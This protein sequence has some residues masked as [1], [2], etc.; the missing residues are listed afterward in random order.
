MWSYLIFK[1]N[2]K[3]L[4]EDDV[5]PVHSDILLAKLNPG[6]VIKGLAISFERI[7]W[8]KSHHIRKSTWKWLLSKVLA[9]IMPN[10]RPSVKW[11]FVVYININM[12]AHLKF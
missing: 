3:Q 12:F 2:L 10:F 6:Q 5:K 4:K 1:A 11:V 8:S 7:Y 9:K